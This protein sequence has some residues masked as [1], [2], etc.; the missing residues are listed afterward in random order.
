MKLHKLAATL[1]LAVPTVGFTAVECRGKVDQVLLYADGSLNILG[2]WRG[3]FTIL[4]NTNGTIGNIP[5]EICMGWY[6]L[7]TKAKADNLNVAVYYFTNAACNA[8]P[9]YGSAPV[10]VYVGL[11]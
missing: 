7:L 9:T 10:P 11:Y 3:D 6:G 4:C 1:L 5:T 2:N 8:L